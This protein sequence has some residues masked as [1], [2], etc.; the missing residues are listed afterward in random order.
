MSGWIAM[1]LFCL[2]LLLIAGGAVGVYFW[3]RY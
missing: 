1:S 2:C 3:R